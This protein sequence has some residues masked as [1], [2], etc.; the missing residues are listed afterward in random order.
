[1]APSATQDRVN[2]TFAG[3]SV[4]AADITI[5]GFEAHGQD[6]LPTNSVIKLTAIQTS[7]SQP[8]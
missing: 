2:G 6:I 7:D 4:P 8:A 1:M 5:T 3:S